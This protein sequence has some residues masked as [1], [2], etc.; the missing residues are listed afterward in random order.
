MQYQECTIPL[1]L[2]TAAGGEHEVVLRW[3]CGATVA[4]LQS[5][6][7]RDLGVEGDGAGRRGP[8]EID[9]RRFDGAIALDD[10]GLHAGLIVDLDPSPP[11]P[12]TDAA[13]I[14]ALEFDSGLDAGRRILLGPGRHRLDPDVLVEVTEDGRARSVPLRGPFAPSCRPDGAPV[15]TVRPAAAGPVAPPRDSGPTSHDGTRPFHRP[16][17]V[18]PTAV[19]TVTVPAAP[20]DVAGDEAGSAMVVASPMLSAGAMVAVTGQV[21]YAVV[22]VLG[23]ALLGLV[24]L[25]RRRRRRAQA[26]ARAAEHDRALQAFA[27]E[28]EEAAALEAVRRVAIS[29]GPCAVVDRARATSAELWER[30]PRC[31]ASDDFLQVRLGCGDVPWSPPLAGLASDGALQAAV[32]AASTLKAAPVVVDLHGEV[33]LGLVG[34]RGAALAVARWLLVQAVVLH[35]PADL[36]CRVLTDDRA[37][38]DWRW[39]TWLPHFAAAGGEQVTDDRDCLSIVDQRA[40]GAGDSLPAGPVVVVAERVGCLPARCDSV[41]EIADDGRAVLSRP[42]AG[43]IGVDLDA[44]GLSESTALAC[45]RSLARLTDPAAAGTRSLPSAVRLLDLVPVEGADGVP[46]PVAVLARW[47]QR[48]RR[49]GLGGGVP[50]GVAASGEAVVLDLVADGPHALIG[51]TTGAGKSELLRT[52][53]IA[54]AASCDPEQVTF[55]LVDFKGGSAFDRCGALPHVIGIV[56]DLDRGLPERALESLEAELRHREARLRAAG[57]AD[58][59]QYRAA[60]AGGGPLPRLV[61]LVDEFAALKTE[62]PGFVDTLVSIAQRGRSLGLHLILA[63]QRP[64]GAVSD[65][66]RANTG[67]RIALRTQSVTDSVDILGVDDAATLPRRCPGRAGIR[68][69]PG[70]LVL[71]QTARCTGAAPASV[72]PVTVTSLADAEATELPTVDDGAD[73][74]HL[75]AAIGAAWATLARP[76]PR[77]LWLPPLPAVIPLAGLLPAGPPA[78]SADV[79]DQVVFGVLDDPAGQRQIAAAWRPS[80]GHLLVVGPLGSGTST[81]LAALSLAAAWWAAPDRCH[82]YVVDLDAGSL[83]AL[84]GLPH[85]GGVIGPGQTERAARLVRIVAAEVDRRTGAGFRSAAWPAVVLVVDGYGSLEAA[86]RDTGGEE[87]VDRLRAVLARGPEV[88]VHAVLAADRFS[89]VPAAVA[90]AVRQR[91]VLSAADPAEAAVAGVERRVLAAASGCPGRGVATAVGLLVQGALPGS[92]LASAVGAVAHRHLPVAHPVTPVETLPTHV[93]L[94]SLLTVARRTQPTSTRPDLGLALPI[95]RREADLAIAELVI[96]P[97]EGALVAGPSRSGRSTALAALARA[98]RHRRPDLVVAVLAPRRSPL[99]ERAGSGAVVLGGPQDIADLRG[100]AGPSLVLVDD[101][102]EVD[103][104]AGV[105]AGLAAGRCEGL[106][107]VAAGRPDALRAGY[108]HWSRE[109]RRHRLGLLLQPAPDL[110]GELLGA[111]LPRRSAA[112]MVTGRGYLVRGSEIDLVQVADPGCATG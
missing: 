66:I 55:V 47:E 57:C 109:L 11:W 15:F 1:V 49:A 68:L 8:I 72:P 75:T 103:D 84:A 69:G 111:R 90:A 13:P 54:L 44:E 52:L 82:L 50:I 3:R 93:A 70:E 21:R 41:L 40:A 65:D 95:G 92:D 61:I 43:A 107:L 9:G 39:A 4:E 98:A 108:G 27:V 26:R 35:G 18:L 58:L 48:R 30:S 89:A 59:D 60:G 34:T 42:R 31:G 33:V 81:M 67:I 23:P 73:L 99:A 71:L 78:P 110:D 77:R 80:I 101:A 2:R 91:I 32:S 64:G 36:A 112:A 105:L 87:L 12:E 38:G 51:G 10:I 85:C 94:G 100:G 6:S 62:L 97:G 76:A 56:T 46:D 14:V 102:D 53:V 83:A 79:P 25:R 7:H 5:A 86:C 28:L 45:A 88:G 24:S 22:G 37:S 16:P 17:R 96:E 63:T 19:A 74:E 20:P 29:P 106:T 104:P